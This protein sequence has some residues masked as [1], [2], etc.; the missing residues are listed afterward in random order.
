MP[1]PGP[2]SF[3]TGHLVADSYLSERSERPEPGGASDNS[4][5]V[6]SLWEKPPSQ[7]RAR[8]LWGTLESLSPG[9]GPRRRHDGWQSVL[10]VSIPR[11]LGLISRDLGD[12]A[13]RKEDV[14]D[15][16]TEYVLVE[17]AKTDRACRLM[18]QLLVGGSRVE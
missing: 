7:R 13:P 16:H 18:D 9:D 15:E 6:G 4:E 11:F 17:E 10:A 8:A 12:M 1:L 5:L 2:L 3:S 14:R